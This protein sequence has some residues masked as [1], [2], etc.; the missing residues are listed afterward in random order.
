MNCKYCDT[1]LAQGQA[2]CPT[3]GRAVDGQIPPQPAAEKPHVP[4]SGKQRGV[5]FGALAAL[6]VLVGIILWQSLRPNAQE[7]RAARPVVSCEAMDFTLT[8]TELGYYYWSEF[9][10]FLESSGQFLPASLD[11]SQPLEEQMYDEQTTWQRYILDRTLETVRNTKVMVFEAQKA[12]FVLDEHYE[13]SLRDVLDSFS[14]NAVQQGFTQ[15]DGTADIQAYLADSFGEGATLDSFTAYLRDSYLAAAYADELFYGPTF[16]DQEL[17]DYYDRFADDYAQ[18]GLLKDGQTLRTLRTVLLKP[19]D[20]ADETAWQTA[21]ESAENLY[22]TWRSQS[23]TEEDFAAMAQSHSA[24]SQ[25]A[26][27]GGLQELVRKQS[28]TGELSDWAFDPARKAGD[29]AVVR[30]DEGWVIAYYISAS[31]QTAWQRQAEEDLRA[32][33]YQ[34]TLRT[35]AGQYEFRVDYEAVRMEAP[36]GLYSGATESA[37]GSPAKD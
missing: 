1:Q 19:A 15:E 36:G 25:T 9:F 31:Q 13:T 20:L 32:E 28:L 5:F 37:A 18:E 14:Q 2:V 26:A 29:C 23:G 10:Y 21:K 6:L 27:Q 12:G 35:I 16:T 22:A 33:T 34:N 11:P 7:Q 3:C 17:S 24:D 8:N 4:K 30:T